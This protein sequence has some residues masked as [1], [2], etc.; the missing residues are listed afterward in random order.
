M[1]RLRIELPLQMPV[2]HCL[3]WNADVANG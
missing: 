1:K 2:I 3:Q